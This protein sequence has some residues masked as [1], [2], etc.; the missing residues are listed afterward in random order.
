MATTYL[1][2]RRYPYH[3]KTVFSYFENKSFERD[4]QNNQD[5]LKI[6]FLSHFCEKQTLN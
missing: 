1:Q 4:A 6:N 5:L 2:N 3:I